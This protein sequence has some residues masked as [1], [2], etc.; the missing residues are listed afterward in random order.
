MSKQTGVFIVGIGQ[1]EVG[2][3]WDLSLRDLSTRA[4]R[5]A[6]QD[7]AGLQP[8]AVYVGNML[9]ASASRQ[10]NL[11]ALVCEYAGLSRKAEGLTAEVAEAS[12][13]VALQLAFHAIRSGFVDVVA[14]VGVEKATDVVGSLYDEYLA[15]SLDADYEA[16]EGLTLSS[17][18]AL[19][20]QRYLFENQFPREALAGFPMIAHSNAVNNPH[21]MFRKSISEKLY[22]SAPTIADPLNLFDVAPPADGAAA[23]ILTRADLIPK[24]I[25]HT[26]V[27]VLSSSLITGRLA[28]HDRKDPLFFESAAVSAQQAC[29]KAGINIAAL[30]F[31]E[32]SDITTLHAVLSL[33]AAGFA[34]RGQGWKL[35]SDGSLTLQ[36]SLPVATMGGH[37]ARGFPLGAAGVYQAVEA[38]LQL[39]GEAGPNQVKHAKT[40]M[41][42]S[43]AGTASAAVT[44][45]LKTAD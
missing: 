45:I 42:Q 27:E 35:A 12:G 38:A 8:Q 40:G 23:L 43:L 36:G 20:M 9:A 16:S 10:A 18:S 22:N 1:T 6:M 14:V 26:P 30:D 3:L 15:R 24:G 7:A 21:A 41:I 4:L 31:F 39:R 25:K 17:Q 11:G 28:V 2:E 13:G 29:S 33:E 37:K 5:A 32:Y 44:H 19:L 34:P